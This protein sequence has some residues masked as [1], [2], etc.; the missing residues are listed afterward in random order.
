MQCLLMLL[1][2]SGV[3]SPTISAQ[4]PRQLHGF[5]RSLPLVDP[6]QLTLE[7]ISNMVVHKSQEAPVPA[8][9]DAHVV[10]ARNVCRLV[11]EPAVLHQAEH[12]AGATVRRVAVAIGV[13]VYLTPVAAGEEGFGG[14][15]CL[16]RGASRR[17]SSCR[18]RN[19]T[20]RGRDA[21]RSVVDGLRSN[22]ATGSTF[23][24]GLGP[25]SSM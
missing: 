6:I 4:I 21:T 10:A 19:R 17:W 23:L 13:V 22:R 11:H 18:G 5:L 24:L 20:R 8:V 16:W 9:E 12:D 15:T 14:R 1:R 25:P 7:H 3:V 2:R